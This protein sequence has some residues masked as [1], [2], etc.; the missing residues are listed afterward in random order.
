MTLIILST[1]ILYDWSTDS[2]ILELHVQMARVGICSCVERNY[3]YYVSI[4]I[5]VPITILIIHCIMFMYMYV[6]IL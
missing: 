5:I 1:I 2:L 4:I 3:Y 6:H